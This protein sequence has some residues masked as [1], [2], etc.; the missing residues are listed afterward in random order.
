MERSLDEIDTI[1][2]VVCETV[3]FNLDHSLVSFRL[4]DR[5]RWHDGRP[6]TANDLIY[7]FRLAAADPAYAVLLRGL[8]VE[9]L[10]GQT[11]LFRFNPSNARRLAYLVGSLIM[12]P[13]HEASKASGL[14]SPHRP[15]GSGPYMITEIDSGRSISYKRV[16]NYWAEGLPARLGQYN[17][18]KV[19]YLYFRNN[20]AAFEAFKAGEVHFYWE[21]N[22]KNW[23]TAYDFSAIRDGRV[24]RKE[25]RLT[26]AHPM[27]AFVMN[28]QNPSSLIYACAKR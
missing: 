24:K 14:Q 12:M 1:Y 18:D 26:R 9:Q 8:N 20:L 27:Q 23:A 25:V 5:A 22:A 10:D 2:C 21:P 16:P 7:S 3:C 17:F 6:I 28:F 4:S 19:R 15:L 13:Q 11:V